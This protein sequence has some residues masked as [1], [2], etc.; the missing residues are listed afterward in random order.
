MRGQ[1]RKACVNFHFALVFL[2]CFSPDSNVASSHIVVVSP[3]IMSFKCLG[4][5]DFMELKVGSWA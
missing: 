2:S 3:N 5:L 1:R 4:G